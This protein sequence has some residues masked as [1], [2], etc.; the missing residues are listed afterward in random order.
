[1]TLKRIISLVLALLYGLFAYFQ[2][3]DPDPT[4]WIA[5][6]AYVAVIGLLVFAQKY[7]KWAIIAGV[8]ICGAGFLYLLPSVYEWLANHADVSLLYGMAPDKPYIEES[9]E[10][11]GLLIALLGLVYFYYQRN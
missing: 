2:F 5:I 1:M 4:L 9:R 7:Y 8:I 11:G 10:C 3:N 6:Y